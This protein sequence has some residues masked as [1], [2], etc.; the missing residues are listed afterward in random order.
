MYA[1]IC[2]NERNYMSIEDTIK[3][4]KDMIDAVQ[5]AL[6]I[7]LTTSNLHVG[8]ETIEAS[9]IKNL[10]FE[11]IQ[12]LQSEKD[13]EGKWIIVVSYQEATNDDSSNVQSDFIDK[14]SKNRRF[15]KKI[16]LNKKPLKLISIDDVD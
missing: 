6:N 12:T 8:D 11:T 4:E 7:F 13:D 3:A 16:I 15:Y 9:N 2:Y 5:F 1:N 14:I 10:R